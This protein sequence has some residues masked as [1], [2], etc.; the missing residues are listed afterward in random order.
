MFEG[1]ADKF[2]N[3]M[4]FI[5]NFKDIEALQKFLLNHAGKLTN[6]F[7]RKSS[8]PMNSITFLD[9]KPTQDIGYLCDSLQSLT[10]QPLDTLQLNWEEG[11]GS[12]LLL[13]LGRALSGSQT[14]KNLH[15]LT[16]NG[17]HDSDALGELLKSVPNLKKLKIYYNIPHRLVTDGLTRY[18]SA[19]DLLHLEQVYLSGYCMNGNDLESL[20]FLIRNRWKSLKKIEMQ[21][22]AMPNLLTDLENFMNGL[23]SGTRVMSVQ[24]ALLATGQTHA[25]HLA[26]PDGLV[27]LPGWTRRFGSFFRDMV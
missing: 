3:H 4:I 11:N 5:E 22:I 24:V 21:L 9:I 14:G 19:V 1:L 25:S 6:I 15:S 8:Y 7:F 12:E 18:W 13:C 17:K 10:S 2:T 16:L 20:L 23:H 27:S 26:F